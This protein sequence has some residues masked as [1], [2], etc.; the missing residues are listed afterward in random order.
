[1]KPKIIKLFLYVS[2]VLLLLSTTLHILS[3]F[4]ALNTS[5]DLVEFLLFV[6]IFLTT[7]PALKATKKYTLSSG[8]RDIWKN[9]LKGTPTILKRIVWPLV[10]YVFFNFFFSLLVLGNTGV[11]PKKIGHDYVLE[12]GGRVKK[13]ISEEHYLKQKAYLFRGMTGHV[14]LFQFL[15]VMI[16]SSAFITDSKEIQEHQVS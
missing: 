14:V 13:V 1:M 6:G 2:V 8:P 3:Y 7:I 16:L 9:M 4:P 5:N 15:A 10:G 11:K 12:S